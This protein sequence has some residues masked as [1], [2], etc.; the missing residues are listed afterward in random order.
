MTLPLVMVHGFMGGSAQWDGA[1][2]TIA[3]QRDVIALDLPGFGK[4]ASLPV[5]DRIGSFADWVIEELQNRGVARYNLLGHSMGGMIAQEIALRDGP[6][7]EKLVLYATG[8]IGVLPGRFET[9]AV[10]K[11]RARH[12]GAVATARRISA[13]WFLDYDRAHQY[14][15]CAAVAECASQSAI[16]AGLSA[17]EHWDGRDNL[18]RI[19]CP[20]L[21]LWG[22]QDRTYTWDQIHLLWRTIPNTNLA[23]VPNA[24]H[25]LHAEQPDLFQQ[26]INAFL[27]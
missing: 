4:N 13:T 7:V 5:L 26:V 19:A 15:A 14:A 12:Y 6:R 1:I 17:M 8:S 23:V 10:S 27:A 3:Q 16:Q 9:I 2:S 22:D 21:I 18:A 20:T 24:A 11:E 25:A